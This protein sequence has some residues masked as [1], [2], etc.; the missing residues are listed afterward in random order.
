MVDSAINFAA[1]FFGVSMYQASYH[2]LIVIENT[3][4]NNTGSPYKTCANA[5]SPVG[6]LHHIF[7]TV[8]TN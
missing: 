2:Q 3:G 4:F 7:P 6:K 5:N 8:E 1:G